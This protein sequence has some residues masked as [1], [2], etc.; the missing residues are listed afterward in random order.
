[1][2][3]VYPNGVQPDKQVA[4]AVPIAVGA[5]PLQAIRDTAHLR[6]IDVV[7]VQPDKLVIELDIDQLTV[8][9]LE[10]VNRLVNDEMT[11][12]EQ[13][14]FIDRVVVG[15]LKSLPM[16]ALPDVVE[17]VVAALGNAFGGVS[18][19]GNLPDA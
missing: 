6:N 19:Q 16:R 17:K 1:M 7:V 5:D 11:I 12:T 14:A 10:E 8:G 18:D 4:T 13:I 15:D 2:T 9:D 3:I